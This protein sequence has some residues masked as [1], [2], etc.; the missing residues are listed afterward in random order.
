MVKGTCGG[1]ENKKVRNLIDDKCFTG[2]F[3][4]YFS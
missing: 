2:R 3:D 1:D 4:L